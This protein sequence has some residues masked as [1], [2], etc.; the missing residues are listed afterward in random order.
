MVVAVSAAV[1]VAAPVAALAA[2]GSFTSNSAST[3]AVSAKNTSSGSGAKAVY[4]NASAGQGTTY[5]VYGRAGSS[6]GYGVYSAGRLGASGDLVCSHCVTGG[7]VDAATLPT[8]PNAS[9]LN[10][11]S[12]AYYA[13]VVPFSALVP[14][15]FDNHKLAELDGLSIFGRCT[16]VPTATLIVQADDAT[17]ADAEI[18]YFS[19]NSFGDAQAGGQPVTQ[20]VEIHI[21]SSSAQTQTEGSATYRN[22]AT[23]RIITIDYHLYGDAPDCQVFGNAFTSA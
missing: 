4:G 18:N 6:G 22:N 19:V 20:S 17:A 5:G 16:S 11:H 15:D 12:P 14:G 9:K 2:A 3:P 8:V 21:A 23:G 7:D 1:M 13:R 10:G